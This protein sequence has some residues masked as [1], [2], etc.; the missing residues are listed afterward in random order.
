MRLLATTPEAN[1]ARLPIAID[2]RAISLAE[3]VRAAL[4]IAFIVAADQWLHWPPLLEAAL[5]A[6]LICLGDSGGPIR[7]RLPALFAFM[8]IGTAITIGFGVL[9]GAGM[10]VTVPLACLGI[11]AFSYARIWGQA[12]AQV[13]NLLVVVLVL[14]LDEPRSLPD[15]ALLG[16]V[17]AAGCL[18]AILL[19]MV[20]W[21]IH[22]FRPARHA[23]SDAYRS[24]ARLVADLLGLAPIQCRCRRL[25]GPCPRPPPRGPRHDRAR[26]DRSPGHVA[27]A[28]PGEPACRP[29]AC[30]GSRRSIKSSAPPLPCRTCWRPTAIRKCSMQPLQGCCAYCARPCSSRPRRSQRMTPGGGGRRSAIQRLARIGP[31]LEAM[32]DRN[33]PNPRPRRHRRRDSRSGS[34]WLRP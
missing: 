11:F 17:F 32:L 10:V 20:I 15:A 33:G 25:G 19:T 23:V 31:A 30:Y 9:R 14:A 18:W 28:R 8:L 6:L 22:P 24:T 21:R 1:L 5:A 13:G 4:S 27:R 7:R 16:L 3:G 26:P 34:A 12:S 2:L 29:G